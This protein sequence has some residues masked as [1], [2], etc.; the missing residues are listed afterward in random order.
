MNLVQVS[1]FSEASFKSML[2]ENSATSQARR[3]G[4]KIFELLAWIPPETFDL[5]ARLKLTREF[6]GKRSVPC[7]FSLLLNGISTVLPESVH[8]SRDAKPS[9]NKSSNASTRCS[10]S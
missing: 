8:D 4:Q 10:Q 1:H 3:R 7:R 9:E 2:M 5:T 6:Q